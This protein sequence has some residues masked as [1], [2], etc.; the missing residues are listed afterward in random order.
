MSVTITVN[1]GMSISD[2]EIENLSKDL[3]QEERDAAH[4]KILDKYE[5]CLSNGSFTEIFEMLGREINSVNIMIGQF[6]ID[7][8]YDYEGTIEGVELEIFKER[9]KNLLA[10][11][12]KNPEQFKTITTEATL[13]GGATMCTPGKD[14]EY[15][16]RTLNKILSLANSTDK[17]I[18]Y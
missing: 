9:V 6:P 8:P 7:M 4:L 14:P 16:T 1:N 18:I 17:L 12:E 2:K 11:I 3:S 13:S 15:Y 10:I 5:V